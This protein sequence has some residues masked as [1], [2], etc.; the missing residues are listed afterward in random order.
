MEEASSMTF[1]QTPNLRVE[2]EAASSARLW[3]DVA[4]RSVNVLNREVI[5][6]LEA[7][8]DRVAADGT[9]RHLQ[10]FSAKS[11]GFVV[12]ADVHDFAAIGTAEEAMALSAAGQ[13]LFDK[14]AALSAVTVAVIEGPCL[15]GGLELALACDYRQALDNPNTQFGFPEIELGILPAW[16][17][18]QRLPRLVGLE[19]AL[20]M[21][22]GRT[23]LDVPEA[24]RW[25][26]IDEVV[27][28]QPVDPTAA[29]RYGLAEEVVKRPQDFQVAQFR[30]PAG[31]RRRTS[32]LRRGLR[33][34]L[35]DS[36]ALGRRLA[37]RGAER[38]LRR[39]VPDDMPAPWEALR[40]IRVGLT[41]GMEAG[42][43][44]ECE[45]VG[46]LA[47]TPACRNLVQLFFQRE[48][49]RKPAE[50]SGGEPAIQRVGVVGAGTMGAGI[51]Q[52]AAVR[53]F[54]VVVHEVNQAAL[55]AG[56]GRITALLNQAAQR[57]VLSADEARRKL[58]ALGKTTTWEGFG[59][60]D[61]V[62][63]AVVE[64]LG[65]KQSVFRELERRT[66][67]DAILA[68]NTSSLTIE[69]L[70]QGLA[71]PERVAAVH[72]FNP[73]HKMPLVEVAQTPA[74][75]RH[76]TA[77]LTRWAAALG[78][79]PVVVAD[80][81]GFLVNRIL[82]PYL[83]EAVQ[84]VT[85]GMPV[86]AVDAVMRRFGMPMGPLELLDQVGLDVA[87]HIAGAMRPLV[88]DRFPEN[89]ALEQMCRRGWHGQKSGAGFYRYEG[90][91]KKVH[92]EALAV[93]RPSSPG[94]GEEPATAR[95]RM[96]LLMCNEAA[97]CL[98]E[99]LAARADVIDLAMVLGTGW[100]PHRG[101]PLR[102]AA[103]RGAAEVVR[104]LAALAQRLGP[105]FEP[106]AELRRQAAPEREVAEV[107]TGLSQERTRKPGK[108]GRA[109]SAPEE[110]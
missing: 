69:P 16:G 33:G 13:R 47:M 103:D 19:R 20:Q 73:V 8:L 17:G 109:A 89:A 77:R 46:R 55:D 110:E 23:R 35:I 31:K 76:V 74:T 63:E 97:V 30:L 24:L 9:L 3:L 7:A 65:V 12:G 50:A 87:A 100:A 66:R 102:Y 94:T 79:T 18:T 38:V 43:A 29:R 52:L 72:F 67:P 40:A 75:D 11:S 81:P 95:D 104:V 2:R 39:R 108:P 82:M 85:E 58:A 10:I 21:I 25:G 86:S 62:V 99:G 1:F 36:T 34:L 101:G 53:G 54:D 96:V 56:M 83:N 44:Y 27:T 51:A 68:S 84:L 28:K 105:R 6:E 80:S 45:A 71:H 57:G 92:E 32:W 60:V 22:L 41:E 98:G 90:R 107:S 64:D 48:E 106:C 70:Q 42:L 4:D 14:L 88:G 59:E 37:F 93:L 26:L 61:L 49:A 5:A 91:K 15:G 78:K